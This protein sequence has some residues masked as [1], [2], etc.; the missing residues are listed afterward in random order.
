MQLSN[1]SNVP[2]YAGSSSSVLLSQIKHALSRLDALP[3][4]GVNTL[5]D[6]EAVG[7]RY[8]D[9][10]YANRMEILRDQDVTS[11]ILP[12]RE[13]ANDLVEC[14]F[15]LSH[16]VFPV[17]HQPTFM[18]SYEKMWTLGTIAEQRMNEQANIRQIIFNVTVNL[19]FA[20][21]CQYTSLVSPAERSKYGNDF[22]QRSRKLV[23]F[24]L[25]D[26]VQQSTVQILLLTAVY[27][28][29]LQPAKATDRGWNAV[30]LAIRAAQ[31]AG[32]HL[33]GLTMQSTNQVDREMRRRIWHCATLMDR[34]VYP[35]SLVCYL[36]CLLT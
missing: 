23:N 29:Y 6:G 32:L 8:G 4:S 33:E 25:L 13:V 7:N 14:Y 34:S 30:G 21:G 27:L 16:P 28:F 10:P 12:S 20:I 17:L 11:V 19:V 36:L 9:S 24:E 22:Y 2:I 1:D 5:N 31:D 15:E 3:S 26:G 18:A 35:I